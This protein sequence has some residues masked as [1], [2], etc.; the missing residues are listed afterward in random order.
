MRTTH[1]KLSATI[2]ANLHKH[3]DAKMRDG[4]SVIAFKIADARQKAASYRSAPSWA[5]PSPG[6]WE[7]S[8]KDQE[9]YADS[10]EFALTCCRNETAA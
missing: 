6:F 9:S 8:A 5:A 10:A 7:K 2:L 3:G 1:N 4:S